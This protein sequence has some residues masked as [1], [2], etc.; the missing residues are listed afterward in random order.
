M[1]RS[2][3]ALPALLLLTLAACGDTAKLPVA[4]GTGSGISLPPPTRSLIPTVNV[5]T[6]TGWPVGATPVAARGCV[7]VWP[8]L[9]P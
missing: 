7:A 5:A 2:R 8:L 6:A 4:A 3:I 1:N 9:Q